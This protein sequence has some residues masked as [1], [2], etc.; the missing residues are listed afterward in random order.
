MRVV[1]SD[2]AV[3]PTSGEPKSRLRR[4]LAHALRRRDGGNPYS[5]VLSVALLLIVGF[6]VKSGPA[7][8]VLL[9]QN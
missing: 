9:T 5:P 2:A 3:R 1:D 6:I 8:H 4:Q 7:I